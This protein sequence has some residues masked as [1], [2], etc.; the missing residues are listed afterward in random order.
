VIDESTPLEGSVDPLI[1]K[2]LASTTYAE[3]FRASNRRPSRLQALIYSHRLL[4]P[5][6]GATL[7]VLCLCFNF[8]HEIADFFK[9][10]RD[11]AGRAID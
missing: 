10:H 9:T 7:G 1:A 4:Y 3:T 8:E 2:P 5:I 11:P 6:T